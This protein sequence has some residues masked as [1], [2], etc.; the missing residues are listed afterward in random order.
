VF[1][2]KPLFGAGAMAAAGVGIAALSFMVWAHH[3]FT[4]GLGPLAN[5]FFGVASM[6]IAI[7]TGIK[8]FNWLATMWGGSLR[9]T[10]AML[11]CVGYVATFVFGG[12]S[13]VTLALV[14]IDWQVTDTY[15]VV[16]H[17]H[18]VLIGGK[19]FGLFPGTYY[20]VPKMT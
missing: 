14:P 8:I 6:L 12:L 7:P 13:G 15:Y 17:F 9:F 2:R 19:V 3:M 11:F 1:S 16:A 4:V 20:L 10:T 5:T 18:F